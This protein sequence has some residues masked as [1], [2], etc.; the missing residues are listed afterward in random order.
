VLYTGAMSDA[1]RIK[2]A[3]ILVRS[4][5][6]GASGVQDI[7][8]LTLFATRLSFQDSATDLCLACLS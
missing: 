1:S 3:M 5:A 6:R 4:V 7:I 2:K 8:V